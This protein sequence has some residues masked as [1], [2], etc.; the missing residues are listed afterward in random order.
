MRY[1]VP[2]GPRTVSAFP[3]AYGQPLAAAGGGVAELAGIEVVEEAGD[4]EGDPATRGDGDVDAMG[5]GVGAAPQAATSSMPI[6]V[7]A[8]RA[9]DGPIFL[10]L[11]TAFSP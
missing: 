6:I 5:E 3:A 8:T 7:V 9:G 2:S 1:I 11:R 10:V 4:A